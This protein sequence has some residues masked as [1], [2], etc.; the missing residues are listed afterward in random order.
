MTE[1][2]EYLEF[3]KYYNNIILWEEELYLDFDFI[4]NNEDIQG[5]S[6]ITRGEGSAWIENI[7]FTKCLKTVI[8]NNRKGLLKKAL[9]LYKRKEV[10]KRLSAIAEVAKELNL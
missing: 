2:E 5:L 4:K 7:E 9:A 10:N 8:S 3:N 6:I 1:Y